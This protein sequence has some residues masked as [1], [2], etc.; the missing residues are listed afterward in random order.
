MARRAKGRGG[1]WLKDKISLVPNT[2]CISDRNRRKS[3]LLG[4]AGF[5]YLMSNSSSND[6]GIGGAGEGEVGEI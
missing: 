6:R 1:D 2:V 4:E 5:W 3:E